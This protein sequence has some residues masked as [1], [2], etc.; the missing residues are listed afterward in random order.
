MAQHV[1]HVLVK[2]HGDEAANPDRDAQSDARRRQVPP[3]DPPENPGKRGVADRQ[4]P[5]HEDK[6]K[7]QHEADQ[8][9]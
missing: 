1:S 9:N 6:V 4:A 5:A 2:S 3:L 7:F 8:I